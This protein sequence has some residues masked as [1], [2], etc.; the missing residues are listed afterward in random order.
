MHF[1]FGLGVAGIFLLDRLS[2]WATL[3][4]LPLNTPVDIG[5]PWLHLTHIHNFGAAFGVF[6]HQ[7]W[8]LIGA[9]LAMLGVFW[10]MRR[11]LMAT[12]L[13]RWGTACLIAGDLGNLL[14][15]LVYGAV[16]DFIQLPH[17]PVFNV[18]DICIDFGIILL[19][20]HF[21]T[22]TSQHSAPST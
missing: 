20:W 15:R 18:A 6:Q 8:F 1:R 3:T 16:I 14:D 12:P 4:F 21:L 19:L 7:T 13:S 22:Q 2:K 11:D 5:L 10:W 9:G 17:W